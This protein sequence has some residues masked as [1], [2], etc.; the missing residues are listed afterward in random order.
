MNYI[1]R[2]QN[3]INY[4]EDNLKEP[5]TI[6]QISRAASFS[7]FHFQRLF[8]V[9]TCM[10]VKEYLRKR[11]LST[12][13]AELKLSSKRIIEI[14]YDY[15][16]ETPEAFTRAFFAL[17]KINPTDY[18][19]SSRILNT[20]QKIELISDIIHYEKKTTKDKNMKSKIE[21]VAY[22]HDYAEAVSVFW[23]KLSCTEETLGM[24][25]D[26]SREQV[27]DEENSSEYIEL[28]LAIKEK[29]V[30]GYCKIINDTDPAFED[31]LHLYPIYILDQSCEK[32]LFETALRKTIELGYERLDLYY[33]IN[34]GNRFKKL[35]F[36]RK[37]NFSSPRFSN[38]QPLFFKTE[39]IKDLFQKF[40]PIKDRTMPITDSPEIGFNSPANY[41]TYSWC[42]KHK[43][44]TMMIDG[45]NEIGLK[46]IETQDYSV[47]LSVVDP[48][49]IVGKPNEAVL[50]IINKSGKTLQAEI[51]SQKDSEIDF[52]LKRN[53]DVHDRLV[54]KKSFTVKKNTDIFHNLSINLQLNGKSA[55]FSLGLKPQLA[56][57]VTVSNNKTI[58]CEGENVILELELQNNLPQPV[59]ASFNLP[60]EN[61]IHF[62]QY[63]Y[64]I[65]LAAGEKKMIPLEFKLQAAAAWCPNIRFTITAEDHTVL[66]LNKVFHLDFP[67][68]NGIYYGNNV[69]YN[70]RY[71][72][73]LGNNKFY[74]WGDEFSHFDSLQGTG[75]YVWFGFCGHV[76][77]G[78]KAFTLKTQP[79]SVEYEIESNVVRAVRNYSLLENNRL[80]LT[81]KFEVFN[82]GI[83]RRWYEVKNN[84]GKPVKE[85]IRVYNNFF[86]HNYKW[87]IP[88]KNRFVALNEDIQND[89]GF[90]NSSEF[91]ENW[92]Y[93]ERAGVSWKVNDKFILNNI[94]PSYGVEQSVDGIEAGAT[95]SFSAV[96]GANG[97]FNDWQLFREFVLGR[98]LKKEKLTDS[99][100]LKI[101]DGN[102]F[103][104]GI[105]KF[106]VEELKNFPCDNILHVSLNAEE[107][108]IKSH[109]KKASDWQFAVRKFTD[110]KDLTLADAV[111]SNQLVVKN[112]KKALIPAREGKINNE[113]IKEQD[114]QVYSASNGLL[115][116]KASPDFAPVLFSCEFQNTECF[117]SSFPK[118]ISKNIFG[119]WTGGTEL[120]FNWFTS[121]N[122]ACYEHFKVEFADKKDNFG[123]VWSGIKITIDIKIDKALK[124]ML[125]ERY[126]LMLPESPALCMFSVLKG[127]SMETI[128]GNKFCSDVS[129]NPRLGEG[130]SYFEFKDD[131]GVVN[132]VQCGKKQYEIYTG[133]T[134]NYYF[135][136][137]PFNIVINHC[138]G[139]ASFY[140]LCLFTYGCFDPV[141]QNTPFL[142]NFL[143]FTNKTLESEWLRDLD[144]IKFEL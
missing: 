47:E 64:E 119:D 33:S 22:S 128:S 6:E 37:F 123:T 92:L 34:A 49:I 116:I 118:I 117:D 71:R 110:M 88:Y 68:F 104:N 109:D 107:I 70:G 85:S 8:K 14:A 74:D 76:H 56:L 54:V 45:E 90:W 18:R 101:N 81:E 24:N 51:K 95:H 73:R 75:N 108:E 32:P 143:L 1:S 66:K 61:A 29:S 102:P 15:Q 78:E 80:S 94:Y 38:H 138:G 19:N 121:Q 20:F 87:I 63:E 58:F 141:K 131:R 139:P 35:G 43:A 133:N 53:E 106:Q 31:V 86:V 79:D 72:L 89:V 50:T 120:Y 124:G 40:D 125:L 105:I 55:L 10:G 98:K 16:Y 127:G 137:S 41:F 67:T 113:I 136:K 11:R 17:Y 140:D 23:R 77:I 57:E 115:K 46:K 26:K 36:V 111:I 100:D 126:F 4:I 48:C 130:N 62:E 5:V 112:F 96:T 27:I 60:K 2:I 135:D 144:N 83:I 13:L 21:V 82:N 25:T 91:T 59:S 28:Y 134:I 12:A 122:P 142:S 3:A 93:T 103:T 39:L 65:M 44:L 114:C 69:V 9:A 42:N 84:S 52:S 97:T 30:I 7:V 99:L 132:K 129:L